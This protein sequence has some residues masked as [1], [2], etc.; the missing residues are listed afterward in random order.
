MR[1]YQKVR[2]RVHFSS[3]DFDQLKLYVYYSE[4]N[5]AWQHLIK[6]EDGYRFV[7]M[8]DTTTFATK[9]YVNIKDIFEIVN[10]FNYLP[11]IYE[12]DS[13]NEFVDCLQIKEIKE[14]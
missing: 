7:S 6:T 8:E 3:C 5:D 9:S 2:Q 4:H 14:R 13:L 10:G 1:T 11:T 12:F